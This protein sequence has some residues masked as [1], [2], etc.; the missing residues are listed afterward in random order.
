MVNLK[1]S[2]KNLKGVGPKREEL[3]H[4]LGIYSVE[5]LLFFYPRKYEDSSKI[6]KISG[7]KIG[8]KNTF[9]VK[10]IS[11]LQNRRIRKGL[12]LTSFLAE[13]ESG[14]ME[15]SFFNAFY[16][17]ELIKIGRE[18]LVYGKVDFFRGR[19]SISSPEI[20]EIHNLKKLGKIS[21]VYS[22]TEG[23]NNFAFENL[24]DQVIDL[25]LFEENLPGEV[26]EKYSFMDK[27]EAIKNI[28]YPKSR[29][30]YI[31]ARERLIYEEL[32]LFELSILKNKFQNERRDAIKF[33]IKDEIF[34]FMNNLPFKLTEGQE[35]VVNEIFT[36]MK[37]GRAINR[38][39]Q[40]DV[41][42]GKTIVAIIIM[43]LSYLNG[44]QSSIMAPTEILAKQHFESFVEFLEPLGVRVALLIGSTT[45]K[46]KR[47]ILDNLQMGS[48]DILIGTHALIE[49]NVIFRK[50]GVNV[51]DEQ[52]RF[53]VVQR[54]M[55]QNK[56]KDAATI[57]MSATPI[58]RSLS[59]VLYADLDISVIKTMPKGRKQIK[60]IAINENMLGKSLEF[61]KSELSKGRQA[62]VICSLIEENEDYENL[63]AVEKVYKELSKFFI[64]YKVGLLHG[65]MKADEKN[66]IMDDF[67]NNKINLL[68][69]TTVVE[70]GVNVPN[71]TVMMV[72]NAE[73]FGLST[74]HQLR[75]RVGR[76]DN[77]SYCILYNLS[78]SEISW[79]RMKIM[80]D[81]SDGFYIANKDLELRG[82]GDILGTRQ[83][84]MPNLRLAD[85]FRDEMILK[86]AADDVKIILKE[87][88]N[89][90]SKEYFYLNKE[91]LEFYSDLN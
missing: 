39:I 31:K 48:I 84:G 62:Y 89:L 65:K 85:P 70:V 38:L 77:Q 51:I 67:A 13:D 49:E 46:A 42:S 60:T 69:S 87:D 71:A 74:L 79:E 22:L 34:D 36:D 90:E 43:Y 66:K 91:I 23:L 6:V 63:Q 68:V 82:F 53:G 28:H 37:S 2:I 24:I 73:R 88:P 54:N 16:L 7:A 61:I 29:K 45:K 5:D 58:P 15:I 83:S 18:Y 21:P 56:N 72:Y 81:S 12:T 64:D 76:G 55:L 26:L 75:G 50:L 52:H 78:K 57:V 8:E 27:N 25:N 32:F 9:K 35:N 14:E 59:L 11:K 44:Y 3:F 41:G 17:N 86:Y 30:N 19:V 33:E 1:D 40:G 4:K 20:E 47:D 80:T 10:I